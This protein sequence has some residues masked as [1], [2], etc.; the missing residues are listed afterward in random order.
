MTVISAM[1]MSLDG[2]V[3]LP[4]D[5]PG[6]IFD[7]YDAGDVEL[8]VADG[9]PTFHMFEPS[10]SYFLGQVRRTGCHV[11]GRRLYDLTTGWDGHPGNEAPIVVLTHTPPDDHPRGGV[12]Y[13]FVSGIHEAITIA[14]ALAAE[15]DV[16]VA[17]ATAGRAALDAGLL[18]VIDVAL[19]PVI[20]GD[21]IPWFAGSKG[22]VGLSDPIVTQSRGVVHL[23]Y[24]V[25]RRAIDPGRQA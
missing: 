9:W 20:L 4:D 19:V 18:D 22:P 21:G 15:L 12:D 13:H 1:A 25:L 16:A 7:F 10:A 6:P 23:R 3:A 5:D 17:G 24:E 14:T 11:V 8:S 2:F